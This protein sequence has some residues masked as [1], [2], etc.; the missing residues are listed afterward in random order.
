MKDFQ[1]GEVNRVASVIDS[2]GGKGLNEARVLHTLGLKVIATGILAGDSGK[3]FTKLITKEGIKHNFYCA[4]HG[5]TRTCIN[6]YDSI[7]KTQSEML[8]PGPTLTKQDIRHFITHFQ[9]LIK[10]AALVSLCGGIPKGADSNIYIQLIKICQQQHI[11]VFLDTSGDNLKK[12]LTALPDL[13]KP[14]VDEIAQLLNRKNFTVDEA[15]T[16]AQSQV[17]KG[18]KNFVLSLGSKGALLLTKKAINR[19]TPPNH[20]IQNTVGC[21][22]TMVAGFIVGELLNL[23]ST[24]KLAFATAISTQSSM[25]EGTAEVIVS[26]IDACYPKM[27]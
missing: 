16:F 15:I 2:A 1:V 24:D 4:A 17:D 19:A 9:K 20:E 27:S 12:G 21:G 11:K 10:G 14:N 5:E 13:V 7:N 8:E 26:K 22:D 18:I 3:Y 6:M 23:S 25:T